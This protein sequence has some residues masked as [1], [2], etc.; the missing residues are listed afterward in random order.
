MNQK[1]IKSISEIIKE[2]ARQKKK[3]DKLQV[4]MDNNSLTL[5]NVLVL[6]YDKTK[7]FQ[8]P[9]SPPPYKPSEYVDAHGMLYKEAR[10]LKYIVE[11]FS[12]SNLPQMKREEIFINMLESIDKKDAELL[13][14]HMIQKKPIPGL[15]KAVVD[16]YIEKT[17][18]NA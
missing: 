8:V 11:G 9:M 15:S 18:S 14:E 7:I 1:Y 4:L 5:K 16:E 10:K 3:E 6:T 12:N 17:N 2:A 13:T